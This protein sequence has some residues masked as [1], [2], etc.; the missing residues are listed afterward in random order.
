M[1]EGL[2]K[3][4]RRPELQSVETQLFSYL[5]WGTDCLMRRTA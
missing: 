1:R 2:E 4:A 5:R 3:G